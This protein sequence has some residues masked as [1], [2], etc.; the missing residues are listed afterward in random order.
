MVLW[1]RRCVYVAAGVVVCLGAGVVVV[2]AV[3]VFLGSLASGWVALCVFVCSCSRVL[4]VVLGTAGRLLQGDGR[5]G[6]SGYQQ[7]PHAA[8]RRTH[9]D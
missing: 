8:S 3:C 4:E 1:V 9:H 5:H 6:L 2:V 7:A